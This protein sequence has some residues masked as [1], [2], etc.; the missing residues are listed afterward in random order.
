MLVLLG[1][2]GHDGNG[3]NLLGIVAALFS[4]VGLGE[5]AAHTDGRLG[6]GEVGQQVGIVG[7]A[8]LLPAGAA[9][10]ELRQSAL[11]LG[12]AFEE[13]MAFFPDGKVGGEFNVPAVGEAEFLE[14]GQHTAVGHGTDGQTKGFTKSVA[15]GGSGHGDNLDALVGQHLL[16]LGD[17][18]MFFV[19]STLGAVDKALA[20][21]DASFRMG[22]AVNL[23]RSTV[24]G[25]HGAIAL[26][27]VAADA[28]LGIYLYEADGIRVGANR[29]DMGFIL[30]MLHGNT[31]HYTLHW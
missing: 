6:G 12:E 17:P 14:G 20:A 24:D 21:V 29:G 31:S 8:V 18:G 2:A 10:S 27:G 28:L 7:F 1:H 25:V 19:N 22:D 30:H 23:A 3:V 16:D 11:A 15:D 26:A 9:G 4:T 5:G 13:F